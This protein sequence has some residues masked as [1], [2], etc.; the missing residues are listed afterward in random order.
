MHRR[1]RLNISK[2]TPHR[3][4]VIFVLA[5]RET[6]ALPLNSGRF[7]PFDMISSRP[8]KRKKANVRRSR[9]TCSIS[10]GYLIPT[11][12]AK[13]HDNMLRLCHGGCGLESG[14]IELP[15]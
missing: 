10:C 1:T 3:L 4:F 7:Q 6:T 5:R 2:Y 11:P 8:I 14:L 15:P 12:T 13:D 9:I